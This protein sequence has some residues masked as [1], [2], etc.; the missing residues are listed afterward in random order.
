MRQNCWETSTKPVFLESDFGSMK[1]AWSHCWLGEHLIVVCVLRRRGVA[2]TPLMESLVLWPSAWGWT[3]L[4]SLTSSFGV[5]I[6]IIYTLHLLK[7]VPAGLTLCW[8]YLCSPLQLAERC[9]LPGVCSGNSI[10]SIRDCETTAWA[11]Y[12]PGSSR[13]TML[14]N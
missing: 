14:S 12:C 11:S 6:C 2:W 9:Q 1:L 7:G 4:S 10:P 13:G 3:W 8:A 5:A